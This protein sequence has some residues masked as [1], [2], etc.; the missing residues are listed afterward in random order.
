MSEKNTA[1]TAQDIV[2]LNLYRKTAPVVV[3][4]DDGQSILYMGDDMG[5][6][7]T[8]EDHQD[9]LMKLIGHYRPTGKDGELRRTWKLYT[10]QAEWIF[11]LP[12]FLIGCEIF[13]SSAPEPYYFIFLILYMPFSNAI[14]M[15]L[16]RRFLNKIEQPL[17]KVKCETVHRRKLPFSNISRRT[18]WSLLALSFLVT[19]IAIFFAL[20]F[21]KAP[22]FGG[23]T[24]LVILTGII[25]SV[26]AGPLRSLRQSRQEVDAK[27][28]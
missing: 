18:A 22:D 28:G 8:S 13:S 26:T 2:T 17:T 9:R 1:A 12:A 3:T 21:L 19:S 11:L 5:Y 24:T 16:V 7:V 10:S 20:D 14:N 15:V 4:M 6:L 23:F 27:D 25:W